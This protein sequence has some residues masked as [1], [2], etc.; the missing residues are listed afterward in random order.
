MQPRMRDG[1]P[2]LG[3]PVVAVE[4]QVEVERAGAVRRRGRAVTP[5]PPL[6]LEQGVE[7]LARRQLG[8]ERDRAVEKARLL[9]RT[10]RRGVAKRGDRDD[11][12]PRQRPE[13]ADGSPQRPLAVTEVRAEPD[14]RADHGHE[15]TG[16]RVL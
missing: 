15:R 16:A 10:D 4:Q 9:E 6:Q 7:Q 5:E 14:E 2:R 8:L 1:E 13:A 11:A 3:D 12:R